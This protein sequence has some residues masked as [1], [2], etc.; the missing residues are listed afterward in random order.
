MIHHRTP[1][2][3][4]Q[5]RWPWPWLVSMHDERG[6]CHTRAIISE[7]H[8]PRLQKPGS[9]SVVGGHLP[10]P[11]AFVAALVPKDVP[12]QGKRLLKRFSHVSNQLI[13]S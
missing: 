4:R 8:T 7:R 2:R 13:F 10:K 5:R 3:L 11:L 6:V 12:G 1:L 9:N